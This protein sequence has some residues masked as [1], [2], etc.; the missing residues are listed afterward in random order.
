MNC[1]ILRNSAIFI[2][3][4][5][6]KE[7]YGCIC[8]TCYHGNLC[9][10]RKVE[11][12]LIEKKAEQSFFPAYVDILKCVLCVTVSSTKSIFNNFVKRTNLIFTTGK[13]CKYK[14]PP[15]LF[16]TLA[17]WTGALKEDGNEDE[18]WVSQKLFM[19]AS[20]IIFSMLFLHHG[21]NWVSKL[22][23]I[24]EFGK[25]RICVHHKE[26]MMDRDSS[27]LSLA[28]CKSQLD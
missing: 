4:L 26:I 16:E 15:S 21:Q 5:I 20:T 7:V 14:P 2:L 28:S 13:I 19:L 1:S 10:N 23:K 17:I 25:Y 11:N 6:S 3:A 12:D 8:P 18:I 24:V 22:V 27:S 9:C